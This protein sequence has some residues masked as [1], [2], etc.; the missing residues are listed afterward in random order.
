MIW[1]ESGNVEQPAHDPRNILAR[2]ISVANLVTGLS[3]GDSPV[4]VTDGLAADHLDAVG[5]LVRY[6]IV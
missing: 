3:F 4:S 6:T 5:V 1:K 2:D